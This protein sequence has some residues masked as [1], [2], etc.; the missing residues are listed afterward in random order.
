MLRQF[1]ARVSRQVLENLETDCDVE[2]QLD[3][4]ASQPQRTTLAELK[5]KGKKTVKAP[6]SRVGNAMK[7]KWG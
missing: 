2:E 6:I 1:Q 5:G 7:R 4:L 3:S